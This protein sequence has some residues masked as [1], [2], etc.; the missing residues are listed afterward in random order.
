M[1]LDIKYKYL[2]FDKSNEKL[3]KFHYI[4]NQIKNNYNN[5]ILSFHRILYLQ[6][7][8]L[9]ESITYLQIDNINN[10]VLSICEYVC[11]EGFDNE[12]KLNKLFSHISFNIKT[13]INKCKGILN[14]FD[15]YLTSN[16]KETILFFDKVKKIH[17]QLL[18]YENH[19][20]KIRN[21]NVMP[22]G[23]NYAYLHYSKIENKLNLLFNFINQKLNIKNT[24]EERLKLATIFVDE[25]LFI[26]PFESGNGR[27]AR[28]CFSLLLKGYTIPIT[29]IGHKEYNLSRIIY[30][31]CLE[32][33][34]FYQKIPSKLYSML[35]DSCI[36][37]TSNIFKCLD[38]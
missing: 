4:N 3:K 26:H 31:D 14:T 17:E 2:N 33:S 8:F 13:D 36:I 35:L 27:C 10:K 21:Y 12:I 23:K 16:F 28:I 7:T 5:E 6:N 24:F 1:T 20:G 37:N 30:I 25:F 18:F 22:Y 32:D 11:K 38:L 9:G 19:C 29:I 34:H 15:Q